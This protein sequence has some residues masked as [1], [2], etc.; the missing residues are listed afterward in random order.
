MSGFLIVFMLLGIPWNLLLITVIIGKHLFKKPA[1]LLLLNLAFTNLF[2]CIIIMPMIISPAIAGEFLFGSSD[3]VRCQVCH[4][5][6]IV[7]A[8]LLLMSV[9]NV[10]LLS[11]DRF[12]YVK[13]PLKYNS[14]V[15]GKRV[16]LVLVLCWLAFATFSILPMFGVGFISFV[17]VLSMCT[18]AFLTVGLNGQYIYYWVFIA[19]ACVIPVAV[20]LFVNAWM[21]CIVKKNYASGYLRA[22]EN[23]KSDPTSTLHKQMQRKHVEDNIRLIQVFGALFLSSIFTWMPL[24]IAVIMTTVGNFFVLEFTVFATLCF[25]SQSVIH[26]I[27]Q[28]LLL[29]DIRAVIIK[30]FKKLLLQGRN[31]TITESTNNPSGREGNRLKILSCCREMSCSACCNV[32]RRCGW[33]L[34]ANNINNI[35]SVESDTP[36]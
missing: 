15:T 33:A 31:V 18:S 29:Q 27:V 6:A 10:V 11:L 17:H 7:M 36:L 26:P 2:L 23:L 13:I 30:L 16:A 9:Y 14:I 19:L 35:S 34:V 5:S 20:F 32:F 8:I 22:K 21:L 3:Y 25:F 4:A 24:A 28:I 1:V 12:L